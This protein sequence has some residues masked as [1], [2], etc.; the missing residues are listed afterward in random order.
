METGGKYQKI[1]LLV[2]CNNFFVSCERIFRPDL[3]T[4]PVVVLSNNDGCVIARSNEVKALGIKMGV[5]V[6]QITD[7]IKKYGIT[8]FS[9]NFNL[10]LDISNRIMTTLEMLCPKVE[11]YSVDEAFLVMEGMDEEAVTDFAYKVKHTVL[12]SIGVPVGIGI[13]RTK[14]MAKLANHYAKSNLPVTNGIFSALDDKNRY[15]VLK[16]YDVGEVW[17]IGR[18]LTEKLTAQ[19]VAT[20]YALSCCD[21][22]EM[23]KQYSIVLK[24]T[25]DELNNI[26]CIADDADSEGQM[27][28]MWSRSFKER[29]TEASDLYEAL[30]NYTVHACEKLRQIGKYAGKFSIHIRTSYFGS[31]PKYNAHQTVL[32]EHPTND[33][34]TMLKACEVM[35][36]QIYRP[37]FQYA[38]AGVLLSDLSQT[39]THQESLFSRPLDSEEVQR[40]DAL[41]ATI[42]S[43]NARRRDTVYFMPQGH[44]AQDKKFTDRKALSPNYTTSFAEL[45]RVN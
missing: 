25:V 28:I 7:L 30:C 42:D 41:M 8:V 33:S 31:I 22:D 18:Q 35:L 20:A 38:K 14:T 36:S 29:I 13:A 23:Q 45:P 32:F 9:S 3:A 4:R 26:D 15:M 40:S 34:R 6:F 11:I 37:G 1:Y 19:G 44:L 2:D 10:Y 21:S 16:H 17:G 27:Q 5:P 43:I 12:S 24:R 39:R